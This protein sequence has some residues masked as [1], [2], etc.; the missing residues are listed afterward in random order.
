MKENPHVLYVKADILSE[1]EDNVLNALLSQVVNHV[2][3][4]HASNVNQVISLTITDRV[5]FAEVLL[6]TVSIVPTTIHVLNAK[7]DSKLTEVNAKCV[8]HSSLIVRIVAILSVLNVNTDISLTREN[9]RNV[10]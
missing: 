3:L 4:K 8:Q 2:I 6:K 7:K 9:V 10:H 1:N 5:H